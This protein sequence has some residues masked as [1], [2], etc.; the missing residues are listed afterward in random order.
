MKKL[1][2]LSM[3]IAVGVAAASCQKVE[4]TPS[5]NTEGSTFALNASIAQTKTS[6]NGVEV[7]WEDGDVLYLVTTD[8][9]WGKPYSEDNTT[10]TIAE[11][12]YS[13]GTFAST[14]TIAN[15]TYTFNA[16]YDG[17]ASQKSYH[18]GASTTYNLQST[19]SQDCSNP[20]GHLKLNDAL[21]GTFKATVP[22][23]APA[24]VSM[25]HIFAIM[26]VDVKNAT[27]ADV[28]LKSFEM[29]AAGAT[30]A[31]VFTVNFANSPIDITEKS[32]QSSSIKVDLTNGTVASGESLPVYFVMAP[33]ADYSGDVTFTVTDV[34]DV[35]YT[36]TVALTNISFVAGSLNTTPYTIATGVASEKTIYSTE[37]N[38]STVT[39]ND[40][41]YYDKE[42]EYIGTDTD[43]KTSWGITYGNW[44]GSNCAQLRVYSAGNFGSV[45]TK[46]DVSYATK[47]SYKAKVSNTDLTL[48]T[49]YSTDSGKNWV[50]VDDAKALSTTLTEYSFTISKTGEF[51]KNRIKFE[52]SGT[53]PSSKN[54]QLTI[55]DVSIYGNGEVLETV[56]TQLDAPKNLMADVSNSS[57]NSIDVVWDA[58]DNAGSYM[59]TAK[60]ASGTEVSK[61]VT[62]N[63]CTFTGL[64]YN[65]DYTISVYAK[66]SDTGLFTDSDAVTYAET[67]TTGARP[68]GSDPEYTLVSKSLTEGT[69][70][71]AALSSSTY[72]FVNGNCDTDGIGVEES[73]IA[74]SEGNTITSVPSGAVEVELVADSTNEG[75]FFFVIRGDSDTYLYATSAKTSLTWSTTKKTE[76]FK[77]TAKGD[78][79]TLQGISGS[80]VSQ[81]GSKKV[82]FIRNY[83][84]TGS[85]Y[86][87]IYFFKKN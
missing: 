41:T 51:A 84:S 83:A 31:G 34:N 45:Y 70:L 46:F 50:K 74:S 40:Q 43:A 7:N 25:S 19:Q 15:G 22:M 78:G 72:Y 87:A 35:K 20:T 30:L 73:G 53:K 28:E 57:V 85:Y 33:L 39:V 52:V 6:I 65:T 76:S 61:E 80:K 27:G 4:L 18:R 5:E 38:Y 42:D 47:V 12:T 2:Y 77:P 79:F 64:E 67:I 86:N 81:N 13:A 68:E 63:S 3:A 10:S 82:S 49:Y 14:A 58:V 1:V 56:I 60:P 44:N 37:F 24:S 8:G 16:L 55:D 17:S 23:A 9:T 62:T 66:S 29:S 48:N 36:K 75:Y 32:S 69:Y 11:Y 21:V 71:I 26:R 54:Y 59:V